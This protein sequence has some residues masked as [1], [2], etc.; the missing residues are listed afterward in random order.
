MSEKKARRKRRPKGPQV[1]R[2]RMF[3]VAA[4]DNASSSPVEPVAPD[5]PNSAPAKG[6][7]WVVDSIMYCLLAPLIGYPGWEDV[8]SQHK[9]RVILM[10]LGHGL[11]IAETQQATEF[12]TMLYLS[13]ASLAA[14]MSHDWAEVYFHLFHR[15]FTNQPAA[16]DIPNRELRGDQVEDLTR[17]RRWLYRTQVDQLKAKEKGQAEAQAQEA[18]ADLEAQRP[19]LFE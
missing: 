9:D 7:D 17:M 14:P 11:E 13:S 4:S 10:R 6:P 18:A 12:E 8:V 3:D 15:C 19:R 16:E 1:E 5:T 2:P